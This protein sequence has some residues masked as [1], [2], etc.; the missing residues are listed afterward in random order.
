M[1]TR[2]PTRQRLREL[3]DYRDGHLIWRPRVDALGR[4]NTRYVGTIAGSVNSK[5]RR[6]VSVD[7]TLYQVH[8]LVWVWHNGEPPPGHVVDHRNGVAS[9]NRIK[10]LRPATS[11][12]NNTNR[13]KN[14]T[15]TSRYYGVSWNTARRRWIAQTKRRGR[16]IYL[17]TFDC[18]QTAA[19]VRDT[20]VR[21][22]RDDFVLLNFPEARAC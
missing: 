2:D 19:R 7:G 8:R 11:A 21:S 5:G 6:H 15:A 16:V 20:Y 10:N 14:R 13:R 9:D 12:Q 17:G 1:L 3:F 4:P 18:E 22:L